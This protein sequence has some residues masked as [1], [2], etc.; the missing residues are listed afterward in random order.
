M[1]NSNVKKRFLY[2]YW[3]PWP[4]GLNYLICDALLF[5]L[6]RW[7][8]YFNHAFDIPMYLGLNYS[9]FFFFLSVGLVYHFNWLKTNKLINKYLVI[10]RPFQFTILV[11]YSN[12]PFQYVELNRK[13]KRRKE[14]KR[15]I[16]VTQ[17]NYST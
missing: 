9:F 7:R 12:Y 10:Y 3:G 15:D 2:L 1:P 11:V 8:Q 17:Y 6:Y 16:K 13:D 5:F 14:K 4:V